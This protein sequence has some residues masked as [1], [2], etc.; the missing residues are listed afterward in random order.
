MNNNNQHTTEVAAPAKRAFFLQAAAV[1]VSAA[2]ATLPLT[3]HAQTQDSFILATVQLTA[4]PG[5]LDAL[6]KE[7]LDVA[8]KDTRRFDGL[9]SLEVFAEQGTDT[10]LLI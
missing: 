6:C 5:K 7:V 10:L 4:K 1:G 9:I 2:I 3:G 8:L